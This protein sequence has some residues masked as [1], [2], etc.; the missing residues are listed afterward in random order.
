[1]TY[2]QGM[3]A[4][5]IVL[6][7]AM[8]KYREDFRQWPED[9]KR[10]HRIRTFC[11][12]HDVHFWIVAHPTKL[13]KGTDGKYPPAT[14]YDI[15]GSAGFFN[16]TDNGLSIYRDYSDDSVPVTL[17]IQKIKFHEVG[18]LGSVN[19]YHDRLTGRYWEAGYE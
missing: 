2:Q 16:K 7:Q 1:M 15:N 18:G 8:H 10:R 4:A 6:R 12:N 5:Q 11:R 9:K 17:Y 14:L 13:R 19:F 3:D